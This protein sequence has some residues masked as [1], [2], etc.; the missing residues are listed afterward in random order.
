MVTCLPL[1]SGRAYRQ[2]FGP[3]GRVA[4]QRG[5]E[6]GRRGLALPAARPSAGRASPRCSKPVTTS[7]WVG[8]AGS[9]VARSRYCADRV[10]ERSRT[11]R[12]STYRSQSRTCAPLAPD[13]SGVE[14]RSRISWTLTISRL[15]RA[16]EGRVERGEALEARPD[17]GGFSFLLASSGGWSRRWRSRTGGRGQVRNWKMATEGG[18]RHSPSTVVWE[19]EGAPVILRWHPECR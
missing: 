4:A 8:E 14:K 15:A 5:R 11:W 7:T 16:K 2:R 3:P 13:G 6:D 12:Y 9:H 18:G 10:T 17:S 19:E 1:E